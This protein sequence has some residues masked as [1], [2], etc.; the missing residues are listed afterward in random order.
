MKCQNCGAE[1]DPR[2][3]T[4]SYCGSSIS[5]EMRREQEQVNKQGCPKCGSSNIS[6]SREKQGDY[7]GKKGTT[8]V[9]STVGVC[10]DCGYTWYVE[11]SSTPK[12]APVWLWVLGWV[13]IFPLPLTILLLRKKD[14][15]P[16]LK[17]GIIAAAWVIYLIIGIAGG[18]GRNK[19]SNTGNSQ[20][21]VETQNET[22]KSAETQST[23]SITEET[24]T[25]EATVDTSNQIDLVAGE[26]G[27]YGQRIVLNEG[28]DF[29][30]TNYCYFVP[31]GKYQITN[32]GEYP[33]QIDVNKNEKKTET[34]SDGNNY[35]VWAEGTPYLLDVGESKEITVNEG[36]FIEIEEPTHLLLVP[37]G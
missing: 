15:N 37:V 25:T 8:V 31:A 6:F 30:D 27:E 9:R 19:D 17:Y 18:N 14:M 28:T 11:G 16:K 20:S 23:E 7:K 22:T 1:I 5:Y 34:D 10:K 29:P 26:L 32:T 2:S 35:E 24:T 33:T 13:F 36:Y 3:T 4:C 21:V 12:K